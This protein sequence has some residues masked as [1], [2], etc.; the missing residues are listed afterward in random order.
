MNGQDMQMGELLE[1]EA[2]RQET[3]ELFAANDL[4]RE[5]TDGLMENREKLMSDNK[6]LEQ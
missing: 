6:A 5:Q 1:N 2:V 4:L 3:T